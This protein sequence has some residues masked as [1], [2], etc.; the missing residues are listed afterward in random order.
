[1]AADSE[2]S[3]TPTDRELQILGVLWDRGEATVREVYETLR[4]ADPALPIVQNTVQAFLRTMEDK[5][6]VRHRTE[7]R[8]FVYRPVARREET[9][10]RLAS[11]V[12]D[13]V[14]AGAIDQLVQSVLSLRRP[15][16]EELHRLEA[17]VREARAAHAGGSNGAKSGA[18]AA[19]GE[20]GEMRSRTE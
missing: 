9:K 13:G 3:S 15:T 14:F 12:L 16:P 6:L 4:D 20:S 18:R 2:Q 8:S 17:L 10:R 7:G 19:S 11:R 1:M 5:K